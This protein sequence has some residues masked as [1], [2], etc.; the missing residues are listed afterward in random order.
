M[1]KCGICNTNSKQGEKAERVVLATRDVKYTNGGS[2]T[3]IV[4]EVLAHPTCALEF[5]N[6]VPV[7]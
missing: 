7:Q 1:F 4:K 5:R 6:T 2:G 3:E